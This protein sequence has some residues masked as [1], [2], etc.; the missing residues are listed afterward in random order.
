MIYVL[1]AVCL[2]VPASSIPLFLQYFCTVRVGLFFAVVWLCDVSAQP[3]AGWDLIDRNF[4]IK[5]GRNYISFVK[6]IFLESQRKQATD[7]KTCWIAMI[8]SFS[9]SLRSWK[10]LEGYL[11][12]LH[13]ADPS[14]HSRN[15]WAG[16]KHSCRRIPGTIW[17]PSKPYLG[18]QSLECP[19]YVSW[20]EKGKS[21]SLLFSVFLFFGR[22]YE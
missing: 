19:I 18:Q 22:I 13:G 1:V 7:S 17:L 15:H 16:G 12:A 2:Q 11:R 20:Q 8:V 9:S 5:T 4:H 14:W 21:F 6:L 10:Y 3:R